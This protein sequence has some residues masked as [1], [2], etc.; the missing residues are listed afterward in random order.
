M[1]DFKLG[2]RVTLSEK[3]FLWNGDG[4]YKGKS[5]QLE[6]F[7]YKPLNHRTVWK[8]GVEATVVGF[9]RIH[10]PCLWLRADGH[11]TRACFHPDFLSHL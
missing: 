4:F 9:S 6:L 2:D 10:P 7:E 1:H 11:P 8:R 3:F 5:A